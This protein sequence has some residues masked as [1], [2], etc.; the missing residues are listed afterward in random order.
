MARKVNKYTP[1]YINRRLDAVEKFFG[2]SI[3]DLQSTRVK[4]STI[5]KPAGLKGGRRIMT[6]KEAKEF[7]DKNVKGVIDTS[8]FTEEEYNKQLHEFFDKYK[9]ELYVRSRKINETQRLKRIVRES[10]LIENVEYKEKYEKLTYNKLI[11]AVREA[12][13]EQSETHRD[14]SNS[15]KFYEY[16]VKNILDYY[17]EE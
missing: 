12:Y 17:A 16:V 13:A 8:Q 3:T 2:T 9:D 11:K 15:F 1:S 5:I 4:F 6:Y 14:K 7:M 10:F